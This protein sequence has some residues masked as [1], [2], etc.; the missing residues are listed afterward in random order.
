MKPTSTA[1]AATRQNC[2]RAGMSV[3]APTK[4]ATASQTAAPRIEGATC[5]EPNQDRVV[6]ISK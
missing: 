5:N 2:L 4:N 6:R 1:V 3:S